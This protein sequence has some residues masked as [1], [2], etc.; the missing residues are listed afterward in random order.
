LFWDGVSVY[1]EYLSDV[2]VIICPSD[3]TPTY[4]GAGE[5]SYYYYGDLDQGP[6]PCRFRDGS[7]SYLGYA[8]SDSLMYSDQSLKNDPVNA[9]SS[10]DTDLFGA[11]TSM[12]LVIAADEISAGDPLT[13][14][15]DLTAGSKTLYRLREG[16][17]RFFISDINNPAASAQAQSDIFV[18]FDKISPSA[19]EYNHVPGGANVLYMDGHVEFLKY[20][21]EGPVTRAFAEIVGAIS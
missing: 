19:D 13:V 12:L 3:A 15:N 16:I 2:N 1:P 18:Y 7:Y 21:S 8:V 20:P 5:G 6:N 9:L 17:E 10:L 4:V 14:D 11:F